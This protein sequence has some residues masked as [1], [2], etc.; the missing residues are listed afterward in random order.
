MDGPNSPELNRMT[1]ASGSGA[2]QLAGWV[3]AAR[4]PMITSDDQ[5][6]RRRTWE[7]VKVG[8]S[9]T[10]CLLREEDDDTAHEVAGG[11]QRR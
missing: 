5:L 8:R 3:A 1:G 9:V 2:R 6:A 7:A 10:V 4:S 11:G